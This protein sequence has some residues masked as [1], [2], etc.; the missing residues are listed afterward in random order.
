[1]DSRT[2]GASAVS[3]A[4][5]NIWASGAKSTDLGPAGTYEIHDINGKLISYGSLADNRGGANVVALPNNNNDLML[6]GGDGSPG[7]YEIRT[8]AGVLVSTGNLMDDRDSGA[9]VVAL[10]NG[11]LY[12]F[13]ASSSY[14]SISSTWEMCNE[15]GGLVSYGTL[16]D[17]RAGALG[18]LLTNSQCTQSANCNLMLTGGNFA[19]GAWEIRGPS[20]ALVSS[21]S[22]LDTRYQG[23]LRTQD[24]R[25]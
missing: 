11:N 12:I 25:I 15:S 19:P 8:E 4:N 20:G 16:A 24:T 3:L 2:P 6:I 18:V 10:S 21:G 7:N 17:Q 1:M 22:L 5:G 9:G 13:G 14:P 23:E